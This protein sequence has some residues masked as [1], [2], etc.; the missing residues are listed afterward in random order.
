MDVLSV[1]P[2]MIINGQL[3]NN[4]YYVEPEEFLKKFKERQ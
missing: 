1:H 4:P 2:V 3:V